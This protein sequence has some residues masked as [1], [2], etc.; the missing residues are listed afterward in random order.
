[1]RSSAS[2]LSSACCLLRIACCRRCAIRVGLVCLLLLVAVGPVAAQDEEPL[3]GAQAI[4]NDVPADYNLLA[5]SAHLELYIQPQTA[6]IAVHDLRVS[7]VWLSN[8]VLPDSEQIAENL[9]SSFG[10]VLFVVTTTSTGLH[11]RRLDT[12]NEV[13]E[14]QIEPTARG[15]T[16]RYTMK[17]DTLAF[18]LRYQL[19]PD[20][21]D[22][23]VDEAGLVESDESRLVAI[24]MLPY[25]GATPY[26]AETSAYLVL[27]DG[28]GA[29]T[30]IGG[31]QPSYRQVVSVSSY[32]P[33]RYSFARPA[34][35][36]TPLASFGIVHP[37]PEGES[38]GGMA[39]LGVVT[40][41]A[42]DSSV[43]AGIGTSPLS[44]SFANTRFNYRSPSLV[45]TNR[46]RFTE[47]YQTERIAGDRAMRYF[48]LVDE[49]ANWVGMAQRLR[50]HLI[51]DRAVPRL[52]L[53]PSAR[54]AMRLRL[55]MGAEKPGL[56]RRR[57]VTATSFAEAGE[58]MA[59][60]HAAGM[61]ALDVVLVGWQADGYEGNLPK[62]WPPDRHLGG[63]R[64]LERL[65]ERVHALEGRLFLEDDYTLAFL[66]NGGFFPLTDV[67]IQSNLLP[68]SDMVPAHRVEKIPGSLQRGRFLLNP[69]FAMENYLQQDLPRLVA[70]GVDGLE[71][72]WAGELVLQD[73]NPGHPLQR[74]DFAA[75][76]RQMLQTISD[77]MGAVAAQGGNEYVLGVAEAVTRFPLYHH[78]HTFGDVTVPFYPLAT[79]G[80]VRIYAEPANLHTNPE[81]AFLKQLEY[82]LLPVY[83]LTYRDPLVLART[84]YPKLYSSHYLDWLER[85]AAEYDV[86]INQL[87]HTVD[88]FIVG[89]RQLAPQVFETR[90]EDGTRVI[91]NYG[92]QTYEDG[93]VR[94]ESRGYHIAVDNG[95]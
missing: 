19:G 53:S 92:D 4:V 68:I 88:L 1:M 9:R 11:A 57:F 51:E 27:P 80:L 65:A 84:T 77:E 45:P 13:S 82:G 48:F 70:L 29:L 60:F 56:F 40:A 72:R 75:A 34:E 78:D 74:S 31:R 7:R 46:G 66:R 38:M 25:L 16:V 37:A 23:A 71:L 47:I 44:F 91:V 10:S 76:W 36:R 2:P 63:V 87:G 62:R 67:V 69:I 32:G 24:D 54:P 52:T 12:V 14:V 22:V 86:V 26:R 43:E 6:Q 41:G 55:V 58:I 5:K 42:G 28:P 59:A 39:V 61:T 64:G 83:E 33:E 90:Y 20:Y 85:A 95:Q 89:H 50:R 35:Q 79:H 8:P 3:H 30:Y 21:L 93:G 18:G 94:V 17:G 49:E 73:A 15:A 81:T